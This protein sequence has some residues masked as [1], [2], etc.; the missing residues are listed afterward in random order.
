M[1]AGAAGVRCLRLVADRF[2]LHVV[3]Q[4]NASAIE[5]LAREE[6]LRRYTTRAHSVARWS[7]GTLRSLR[8]APNQLVP[9]CLQCLPPT[10]EP[11]LLQAQRF[12]Y[13]HLDMADLEAQLKAVAGARIKLIATDGVFRCV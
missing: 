5:S 3:G 13:K 2:G 4:N 1:L 9:E 11:I 12:R 8:S 10:P 6:R 7:R